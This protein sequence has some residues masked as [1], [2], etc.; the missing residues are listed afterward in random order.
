M[1]FIKEVFIKAIKGILTLI[2]SFFIL[3]IIFSVLS[4]VLSSNKEEKVIIKK[5]SLLFIDDLNIIGD[6]DINGDDLDFNFNIPLPIPILNNSIKKDKISIKTFENIITKAA[7]DNNITGI[8]LN[9]ENVGISFNK[10]VKVRNILENFQLKKPIYSYADLQTKNAYF[11]SSISNFIAVSPPGFI[12]VSGFGISS[13]FFKNLF[14]ELGVNIQ[15]FRVGEYKG[16]AETFVRNNFSVENKE[17]YLNLLDYRMNNYLDKISSSRNIDR[18]ELFNMIERYETE[19]SEDA[20]KNNLIDSLIYEDQMENYLKINVDSSY[21]KVSLLN[22]RKSLEKEKYNRDKIAI[23][24]AIGDILPGSGEDGI[25]SESIIKEIK[26]IKKNSNIK[27]VV[28]YVNSGGGSAFASDLIARELKLLKNEKPLIAYMDDVCAS[29]GYF[30][31]MPAD[32][33][34]ASEGSIVGSIGVFGILPE[35]SGLLNNKLKISSDEI[36]TNNNIGEINLFR[37]LNEDEKNLVQRGINKVYSDFLKIVSDARLIE[38]NEVDKL[39]RGKVYYGDESKKLNLIDVIGELN[40]AIKIASE[41]AGIDEFQIIEYPK[42]KTEFE[43]I[44]SSLQQS[45]HLIE[46]LLKNNWVFESILK[47]K[48]YDPFQMR[49]EYKID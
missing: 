31:S 30:I 13:F 35:L 49:M 29:G 37:P 4:S 1:N 26:K 44:I 24:Y 47:N 17:Q 42:H 28:L 18:N 19:L 25:Y 32:T 8:F 14:E 36:K 43:R 3:I 11:I 12:S 20:L 45:N 27:A 22:Y 7:D 23:L 41:M 38:I 2:I 9:L 16:A 15:L 6:R 48:I 5:N 21:N 10:A 39:A 34:I 33:L 40:D 46:P